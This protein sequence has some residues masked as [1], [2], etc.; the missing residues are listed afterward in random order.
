M[1]KKKISKK[2]KETKKNIA[3]LEDANPSNYF[4]KMTHDELIDLLADCLKESDIDSF[5]GILFA[6]VDVRNKA[7]IAEIMGVSRSTLYRMVSKQGN[8]T[9]EKLAN[10]LEAIKE[11]A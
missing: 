6:Y 4:N 11:A 8:P 10:L 5:K 1:N 7:A 9:L 2:L 3:K